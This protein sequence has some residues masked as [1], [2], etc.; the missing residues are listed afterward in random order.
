MLTTAAQHCMLCQRQVELTFHH[1]IPR[2]MHRRAFFKKH[3]DK[4]Q[5]QAG[6]MLCRLCHKTIHRFYDEMTLAKE[7]NSLALLLTSEKVQQH[8]EWAKKQR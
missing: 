8:I 4:A 5:L 6:I 1:L 3:Y 7:Y 2:K